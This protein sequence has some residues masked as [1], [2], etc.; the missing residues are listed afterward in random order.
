MSKYTTNFVD[1]FPNEYLL[2]KTN[3]NTRSVVVN[4]LYMA[5]R[6]TLDVGRISRL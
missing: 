5:V 2:H 6:S 3:E 1:E 4:V